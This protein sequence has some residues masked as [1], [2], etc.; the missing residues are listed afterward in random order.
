M[1]WMVSCVLSSVKVT[2]YIILSSI[3][4]N[5]F[6]SNYFRLK[7]K[8]EVASPECSLCLGDLYLLYETRFGMERPLDLAKFLVVFKI[9]YPELT[10]TGGEL[11]TA[12]P[13]QII[14]HG[15]QIKMSI[16]EDGKCLGK[17]CCGRWEAGVV[18]CINWDVKLY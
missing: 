18:F 13:D 1:S 6:A 14:V 11:S 17:T 7:Q 9:A 15:I 2:W 8:F 16:L 3:H 4:L 10:V 5:S 12:T